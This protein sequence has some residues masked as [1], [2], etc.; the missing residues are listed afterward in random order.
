MANARLLPVFALTAV[1][2]VMGA[3]TN[4]HALTLADLTTVSGVSNGA[5]VV[6]GDLVFENFK[7]SS[8]SLNASSIEVVEVEGGIAFVGDVTTRTPVGIAANISYTVTGSVPIKS[9]ALGFDGE[10]TGSGFAVAT[11]TIFPD[12]GSPLPDGLSVISGY[13]DFDDLDFISGYDSVA[14]TTGFG[15]YA[16]GNGSVA[17]GSVY[18]LFGLGDTGVGQPPPVIPEPASL[19][20]LPLALAGMGIRKKLSAR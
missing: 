11:T 17:L 10:I 16:F 1:G 20:L 9:I 15:A 8:T 7:F 2:V 19:V 12:G 6:F 5:S 14:V 3:A 18:N 13:N 4:A